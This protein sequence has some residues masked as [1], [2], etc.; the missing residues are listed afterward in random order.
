MGNISNVGLNRNFNFNA[1]YSR[2]TVIYVGEI[3][4][5]NAFSKHIHFFVLCS[6]F[7]AVRIFMSIIYCQA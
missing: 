3:G 4:C 7:L 2:F 5:K 6:D 1:S